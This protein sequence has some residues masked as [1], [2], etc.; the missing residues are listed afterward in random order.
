MD[1]TKSDRD[2]WMDKI[3]AAV[4]SV[5][6]ASRLAPVHLRRDEHMPQDVDQETRGHPVA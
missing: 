2:I 5:R 6:L 3:M 1:A 4:R